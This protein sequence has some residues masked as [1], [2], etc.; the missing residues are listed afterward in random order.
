MPPAI[1]YRDMCLRL[2][3]HVVES[4][5]DTMDTSGS[6]EL[7]VRLGTISEDGSFVPGVELPFFRE[8]IDACD[9]FDSWTSVRDWT[10]TTEFLYTHE[11][12]QM[13]TVR[14]DK[15]EVSH[16]SKQAVTRC[17]LSLRHAV[18]G[19][20]TAARVGLSIEA[21]KGQGELPV[22]VLPTFV[23]EK[24]RKSYVSGAFR[25]DFTRVYQ[26]S[27]RAEIDAAIAE[28]RAIYE[29]EV[30]LQDYTGYSSLHTDEYVAE[31]MLMKTIDLIDAQR[32]TVHGSVPVVS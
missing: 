11:G 23:R 26:G 29:V 27:N 15:G 6:P 5:R 28:D 10:S 4:A 22:S 18:Q 12:H 19:A 31:S 24:S 1:E 16:F 14:D 25:W 21:T 2:P 32:V 30:E 8:C 9:A 20:P 13:R 7:E 3:T 17:D